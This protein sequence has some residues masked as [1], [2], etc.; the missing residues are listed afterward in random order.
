MFN[1]SKRIVCIVIQLTDKYD[2]LYKVNCVVKETK[3]KQRGR[4]MEM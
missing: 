3:V 4:W 2:Q 1:D